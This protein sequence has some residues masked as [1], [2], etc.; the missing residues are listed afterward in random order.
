[1]DTI[2][3]DTIDQAP[4]EHSH[5]R[6]GSHAPLRRNDPA[7][8]ADVLVEARLRLRHVPQ[9]QVDR[10]PVDPRVLRARRD[11]RRRPRAVLADE[12]RQH[13][14]LPAA[15]GRALARH[16]AHRRGRAE[17]GHPRHARRHRRRLPRRD[18]RD[19]H[20]DRRRRHVGLPARVAQR[21]ALGAHQRLPRDPGHPPHHHRGDDVRG[22]AVVGHRRWCSVSSAGRGARGCCARRRCRCAA[23]TSS[24]PPRPTASRC[25]ASSRSRCFPT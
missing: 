17:P 15:V 23:A 11:L 4:R 7:Q 22:P 10:R 13:R 1:M 19:D 9:R 8:E 12:G 20:R 2:A 3:D 5:D 24:R 18:H 16:H 25:A 14:P 21:G 6:D